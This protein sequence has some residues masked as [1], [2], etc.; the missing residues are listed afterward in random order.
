MSVRD[1]SSKR[2]PNLRAKHFNEVLKKDV[3]HIKWTDEKKKVVVLIYIFMIQNKTEREKL[4]ILDAWI[5]GFAVPTELRTE[6]G[7]SHW[8]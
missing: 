3:F 6:A 5:D 8:N 1:S 7:G 2:Q 4:R